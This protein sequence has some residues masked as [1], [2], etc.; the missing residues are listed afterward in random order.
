MNKSRLHYVFVSFLRCLCTR[1][2]P[3][4]IYIDDLQWADAYT[5]ELLETILSDPTTIQHIFFIGAYRSNEVNPHDHPLAK[6][7]SS[8]QDIEKEHQPSSS[9]PNNNNHGKIP[10]S[11]DETMQQQQLGP[12]QERQKALHIETIEL[13]DLSKDQVG[14]FIADTLQLEVDQVQPLTE[15]I[16]RKTLG[17]IFFTKQALEQLVRRNALYF[18]MVVFQ[19]QWRL[20]Q[21]K[22]EETLSDDI[23][24][25]IQSK[26]ECLPMDLQHVLAVAAHTRSSLDVETLVELLNAFRKYEQKEQ[27]NHGGGDDDQPNPYFTATSVQELLEHAVMSGLL[28]RA[29]NTTTPTTGSNTT[30]T[31]TTGKNTTNNDNASTR[32]KLEYAFA[33]DRIREAARVF[34]TGEKLHKLSFIIG[35]V[36]AKRGTDDT[37][38]EDWMMFTAIHHLNSVPSIY[39]EDEEA[40][41]TLAKL[42]LITAKLAMGRAAFEDAAKYA[43]K[44]IEVLPVDRWEQCTVLCHELYALA[45]EACRLVGNIQQMERYCAACLTAERD[46]PLEANYQV[47]YTLAVGL[48]YGSDRYGEAKDIL[49]TL[50][51]HLD[52]RFPTSPTMTKSSTMLKV[53]LLVATKNSRTEHEIEKME[54]MTDPTKMRAMK[55]L[56]R[57]FD[58]CYIQKDD[59]LMTLVIFRA[60]EYTL[61]FGLCAY[62]PRLVASVCCI[63][64]G[65]LND[66]KGGG[67][68]ANYSRQ[69]LKRVNHKPSEAGTMLLSYVFGSQW[70]TPIRECIE[71]LRSAHRIGLHTGAVENAC[72]CMYYVVFCS[73]QA[74]RPLQPIAAECKAHAQRMEDFGQR[75]ISLFC[76]AQLLTLLGI[77]GISKD[78]FPLNLS[79]VESNVPII[80]E[81]IEAMRRFERTYN[82]EYELVAESTVK[83]G[84]AY[85][86]NAPG[87][88]Q[89]SYDFAVSGVS[90]L[91]VARKTGKPEYLREAKRIRKWINGWA[92]QGSPNFQHW[93]VLLD[94]G[95]AAQKGN[96]KATVQNYQLAVELATDG[97]YI[98]DAA[99]A[100]EL[101]AAFALDVLSDEDEAQ[102]RLHDAIKFYAKWGALGKVQRIKA[103][104]PTLFQQRTSY[105]SNA[106]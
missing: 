77:M 54:L 46:R 19:W 28:C 64:T 84:E 81:A 71:P 53:G 22:L 56:D 104:Y 89:A 20:P 15:A 39:H 50:L 27:P 29:T 106:G 51:K 37:V 49:L 7:I 74:G 80:V 73:F 68:Y 83:H 11:Q 60:L 18:D 75:M 88:P 66:L 42:N 97:G 26:I 95:F 24:E 6:I 14:E 52:C 34:V 23:V 17:N 48:F 31:T 41:L 82:G 90:C 85:I 4:V 55:L 5:L 94:A 40:R 92:K 36:L 79:E 91:E 8:L 61:K 35:K 76:K 59:V 63:F 43:E 47:Y 65:A 13:S 99:L 16:Y 30:T 87:I 70:V 86:K 62:S 67:L 1:E 93:K 96:V 105:A 33:H 58:I 25:M 102:L 21:D 103:K 9:S 32:E 44:G 12:Q 45:A 10:S 101:W 69:L 98:H 38:G 57:L 100:N 3:L 72:W 2:S 78:E